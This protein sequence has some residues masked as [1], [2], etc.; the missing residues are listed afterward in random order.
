MILIQ[1]IIQNIFCYYIEV[2]RTTDTLPNNYITTGIQ[3]SDKKNYFYKSKIR[4]YIIFLQEN[5][6]QRKKFYVIV[7]VLLLERENT[8]NDEIIIEN[9]DLR[10]MFRMNN[11]SLFQK[12]L[13][14]RLEPKENEYSSF[15]TFENLEI[16]LKPYQ[17][18]LFLYSNKHILVSNENQNTVNKI[19]YGINHYR[20]ISIFEGMFL[21]IEAKIVCLSYNE[22][23]YNVNEKTSNLITRNFFVW[24]RIIW[25]ETITTY[26]GVFLKEIPTLTFNKIKWYKTEKEK[27]EF[28]VRVGQHRV[29][30]ISSFRNQLKEDPII[31]IK[32]KEVIENISELKRLV[33]VSMNIK[34]FFLKNL[35]TMRTMTPK[36]F[37]EKNLQIQYIFFI[38]YCDFSYKV[39]DATKTAYNTKLIF[40]PLNKNKYLFDMKLE[41]NI[42]IKLLI[43]KVVVDEYLIFKTEPMLEISAVNNFEISFFQN[44]NHS[45]FKNLIEYYKNLK[46]KVFNGILVKLDSKVPAEKKE[47]FSK[48]KR[49]FSSFEKN[50]KVFFIVMA[51]F[52]S[53]ILALL[54]FQIK[55]LAK[56]QKKKRL[57]RLKK[58]KK[59]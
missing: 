40:Y 49:T 59:Q 14:T 33:V 23:D 56:I 8:K 15:Y 28:V 11:D 21:S 2:F 32:N 51:L 16:A 19:D 4:S 47:T 36:F 34:I 10:N 42:Y 48:S 37:Y 30:F 9:F 3:L 12:F 38:L 43:E 6:T 57:K 22:N 31:Y 5:V 52:I 18:Q 7:L 41:T 27:D 46:E 58:L 25:A 20:R 50:R 53:G 35:E 24:S 44:K 55:K 45:E 1:F 54:V 29:N 17:K 26:Q 39:G 13:L